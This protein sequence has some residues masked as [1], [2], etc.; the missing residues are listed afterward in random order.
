MKEQLENILQDYYT[1]LNITPSR[2]RHKYLVQARAAMMVAM[3]KYT[4]TTII[5]AIF[6]M[7]HSSIVYHT[8]MHEANMVSWG[9]YA[10]KFRLARKMCNKTMRFKSMAAKLKH[11]R[12]EMVRLKK[13]EEIIVNQFKSKTYEQ[14]Q[15]QNHE[16]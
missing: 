12:S 5:A 10:K 2:R 1:V 11:V 16:D 7:D 3:R 8:K 6:E 4:T 9:G 13:T 15:V 14:L